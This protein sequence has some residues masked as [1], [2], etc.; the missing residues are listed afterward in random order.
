MP[1]ARGMLL[2]GAEPRDAHG[3]AVVHVR[4]WQEAYRGLMPQEVLD[5][6]SIADR[7]AGWARI[8][9]D[10]AQRSHTLIVE[11]DGEIVGWASFGAARDAD[12]VAT[13]EL[14]G[15]YAH[16]DEWSTGIGRLLLDGVE[17]QLRAEGHERAYLWVLAGNDRA[18]RF[19]E[20][21][22]WVADGGTKV[23]ERPGL[24]LHERRHVADLRASAS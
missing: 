7:E 13:G 15:I 24:V 10:P 18:A 3:I 21:N 1:D 8:I 14:W 6:L 12:A 19:Y 16:P 5:G 17:Q 22:G 20:R 4:S 11:R 2:R 23:D 9:A